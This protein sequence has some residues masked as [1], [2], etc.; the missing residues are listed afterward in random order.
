MDKA[1][2]LLRELAQKLGQT[3]ETLWPHAVRYVVVNA[4]T[5]VVCGAVFLAAGV[6]LGIV[7]LRRLSNH[8][9][10]AWTAG[11]VG[12]IAMLFVG[13]LLVAGRLPVLI[14]PVGA[15][16]LQILSSRH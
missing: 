5:V 6:C 1:I 9:D 4:A 16:V 3:V 10:E 13:L 14:E 2:E 15:L 12:G 7:S 11:A 8:G